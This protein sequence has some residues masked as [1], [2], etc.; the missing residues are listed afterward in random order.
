M[1]Q[2]EW[3]KQQKLFS[4]FG[5]LDAQG[6]GAASFVSPEAFFFGLQMNIFLH[7]LL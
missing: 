5:W 6:Q 3:L 1:P 7:V 2:P 4:W